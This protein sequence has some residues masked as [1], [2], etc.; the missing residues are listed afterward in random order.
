LCIFVCVLYTVTPGKA[1]RVPITTTEDEEAETKDTE[2]EESELADSDVEN[3][4]NPDE[5]EDDTTVFEQSEIAADDS[6]ASV[7]QCLDLLR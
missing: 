2:A 4:L 5:Y 7:G 3:K 1:Q 6:Q